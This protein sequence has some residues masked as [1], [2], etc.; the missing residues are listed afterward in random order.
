M[1]Y[2]K[3]SDDQQKAKKEF[4]LGHDVFFLISLPTCTGMSLCYATLPYVFDN[5]IR[6]NADAKES[7]GNSRKRSTVVVVSPLF[8]LMNDQVA[9]F[10]Q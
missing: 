8:T 7:S 5:L 6:V 1:G 2:D 9:K 3:P 4:V 10:E